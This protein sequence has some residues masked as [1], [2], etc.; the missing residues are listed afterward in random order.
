MIL[1][2]GSAAHPLVA[3]AVYDTYAGAADQVPREAEAIWNYLDHAAT[4]PI[5]LRLHAED[6][7]GRGWVGHLATLAPTGECCGESILTLYTSGTTGR[8]K[9]AAHRV[10]EILAKKRGGA[11]GERW[12]LAY[13]PHRWAGLSLLAHA[14]RFRAV[15]VVPETLEP[16]DLVRAGVESGASHISMTP[17]YL[18]RVQLSVSAE[19]LM[20]LALEQVTF[21]GEAATQS[22]LD[23]AKRLWPRARVTHVYAAT[24]FGD[25]CS[26]SD[27]I[28]GFPVAKFERQGFALAADGELL[29]GDRPTGDLWERRGDRYAFLGRRQEVIN[30]GGAKVFPASV[31][32]AA[33]EVDGV[34]EARAFGVS[35]ALLGQV[36]ALDYRGTCSEAEVKRLLRAKL[37]KLAWPA[38][39]QR[40]EAI[41]LT[42]ANKVKRLES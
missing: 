2:V 24:E 4:S 25:I 11:A 3:G 36:V 38:Q 6:G 29:I 7:P 30:V 40:V 10:T 15:V 14:L 37:P 41:A 19:E 33:L 12:L 34:E 17:S 22:V 13:A 21:G 23:T 42:G 39:V 26:A 32:A 20:R 8:P 27:G 31:E 35:S 1:E 18:R 28:A 5:S 9:P 16:R